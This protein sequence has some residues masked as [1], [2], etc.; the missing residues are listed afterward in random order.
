STGAG[1]GGC[2]VRA[3]TLEDRSV[4]GA[5]GERSVSL[6]SLAGDARGQKRVG[7]GRFLS[8]DENA[9]LQGDGQAFDRSPRLPFV[10]LESLPVALQIRKEPVIN[11]V[12]TLRALQFRSQ[13]LQR[14]GLLPGGPQHVE[15][16]HVA[17]SLP[18]R[19]ERSLAVEARQDRFFDVAVSAQALE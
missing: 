11:R 7:D 10:L 19:V 5:R 9:S 1:A 8:V 17:G 12:G 14:A 15:T 6:P 13:R 2:V 18:D 4:G 3:R 16:H